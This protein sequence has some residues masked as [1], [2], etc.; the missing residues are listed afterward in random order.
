VVAILVGERDCRTQFWKRT[1]QWLFQRKRY[2]PLD[3]DLLLEDNKL[4]F[5]HVLN[6]IW[7]SDRF[8]IVLFSWFWRRTHT[9]TPHVTF[10]VIY[11]FHVFPLFSLLKYYSSSFV[12][13]TFEKKVFSVLADSTASTCRIQ[14][15]ITFIQVIIKK[16]RASQLSQNYIKLPWSS[17][18]QCWSKIISWY[19]VVASYHQKFSQT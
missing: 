14:Y 3:S 5:K 16:W 4:V 11:L 15:N 7:R 9:H 12:W 1:I 17:S 6:F 2:R 8:L 10:M 13:W 18:S 19:K